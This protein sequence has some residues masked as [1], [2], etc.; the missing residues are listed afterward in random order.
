MK[1]VRSIIALM[2]VA[3][4]LLA[5]GSGDATA[6][7]WDIRVDKQE[8]CERICLSCLESGEDSFCMGLFNFC[9]E[10]HD[11]VVYSTCGCRM[12]M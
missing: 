2:I 6:K 7:P 11:G 10:H 8:A 9:C 3:F 5:L 12:E 4:L 1:R